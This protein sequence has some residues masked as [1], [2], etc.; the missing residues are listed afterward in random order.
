MTN[1]A[2][3]TVAIVGID[4]DQHGHTLAA[5]KRAHHA[6][7][8]PATIDHRIAGALPDVLQQLIELRVV[9]LA[10]EQTNRGNL[11]FEE[12][13]DAANVETGWPW[14][15]SVGDLNA[16]GWPDIFVAAGM[17][18]PL[19]YHGNDVLLNEK[20]GGPPVYPPLP[21]G[22]DEAQKV[23]SVNTWETSANE[24]ARRRSIYIFQRRALNMP[25]LETFAPR[26]A[27]ARKKSPAQDIDG[28]KAFETK[29]LSLA[30]PPASFRC[31]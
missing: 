20:V 3:S 26:R 31:L 4:V 19:R 28:V 24:D 22:L 2:H 5:L 8:G 11:K 13:S 17:N 12:M 6:A 10:R 7:N 1:F 9:E 18:Y 21:E 15:P 14:G 29:A 23:Q 16:D 27:F 30:P 25:F